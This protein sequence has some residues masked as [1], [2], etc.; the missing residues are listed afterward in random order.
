MIHSLFR[1]QSSTVDRIHKIYWYSL[2][3]M[4]TTKPDKNELKF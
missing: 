4:N 2:K 3:V 1:I